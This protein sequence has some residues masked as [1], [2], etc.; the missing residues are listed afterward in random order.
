[1]FTTKLSYVICLSVMILKISSIDSYASSNLRATDFVFE[2]NKDSDSTQKITYSDFQNNENQASIP[3]KI[4]LHP[5][6]GSDALV[7]HPKD[8]RS[9]IMIQ[10]KSGLLGLP[11]GFNAYGEDTYKAA[12]RKFME[13]V[14]FKVSAPKNPDEKDGEM[15]IHEIAASPS[16]GFFGRNILKF[17]NVSNF[18][19]RGPMLGVFGISDRDPRKQAITTAY[20]FT[21]RNKY[22]EPFTKN[23]DLL[24]AMF[25]DVTELLARNLDQITNKPSE[26]PLNA[27]FEKLSLEDQSFLSAE[28]DKNDETKLTDL[29]PCTNEIAFDYIKIIYTYYKL[30]VKSGVINPD[31]STTENMESLKILYNKDTLEEQQ[32]KM[33]SQ[34]NLL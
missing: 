20:H 18:N 7:S 5:N 30:M 19:M 12:A 4:F 28:S 6:F 27:L 32:Q 31:G 2:M 24:D 11:G 13:E 29:N 16:P 17:M 21:L 14:L 10:R 22:T 8:P 34:T 9:I 1:M 15:I 25:C 23:K 26:H 3:N 33:K